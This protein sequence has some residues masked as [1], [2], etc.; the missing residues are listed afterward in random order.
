MFSWVI[1]SVVFWVLCWRTIRLSLML[2]DNTFESYVGGLYF[3]V[4]CLRTML[5]RQLYSDFK[6]W[7]L[8]GNARTSGRWRWLY[9][10]SNFCNNLIVTLIN[11]KRF[12]TKLYIVF[13]KLNFG[14]WKWF[15]IMKRNGKK[16]TYSAETISDKDYADDLELRVNIPAEVQHS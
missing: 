10:A 9:L 5:P 6:L 7:F 13:I 15:H 12:F 16:Y 3:W 1:I 2:E 8:F 14:N 11:F 4:L